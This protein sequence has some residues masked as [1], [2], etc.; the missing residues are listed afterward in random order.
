MV[1]R[2]SPP[3]ADEMA[4][5]GKALLTNPDDVSLTHKVETEN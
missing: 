1:H 2:E 5:G 4:Q 3:G